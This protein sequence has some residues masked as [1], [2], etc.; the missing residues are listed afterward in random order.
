MPGAPSTI[1]VDD[2]KVVAATSFA[3]QQVFPSIGATSKIVSATS[4]VSIFI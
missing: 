3:V 4:Q 2:P 1:S